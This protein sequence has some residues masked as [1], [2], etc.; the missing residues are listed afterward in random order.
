M[1]SA[2]CDRGFAA[3]GKHACA[4]AD[5]GDDAQAAELAKKLQ[6]P[7]ASLISVPLQNN[8]DFGIGSNDAM[9]YTL[10]IQPV[11]PFGITE[12]SNLIT[13]TIV[14]IIYAKLP[15][16]GGDDETGLGDIVQS[17]FISPKEPTDGGWIWGAGPVFL[18]PSAT[19][20][21]LSSEKFG[22]G[23]TVVLLKQQSGWTYGALVNHIYSTCTSAACRMGHYGTKVQFT[24]LRSRR[25]LR[26]YA[27]PAVQA[28]LF[29]AT[30]W[31]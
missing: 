22:L 14:P 1:R 4:D 28:L 10:N 9:R 3:C 31:R 13:R 26:S 2:S 5:D 29:R 15:I 19:E 17:F 7:I 18:Y 20:D 25:T 30:T 21:A 12:R 23:P 8:W 27:S 6:N 11:I 16:A 24:I